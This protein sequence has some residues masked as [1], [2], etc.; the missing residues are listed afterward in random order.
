MSLPLTPV[1]IS[2]GFTLLAQ[3]GKPVPIFGLDLFIGISLPVRLPHPGACGISPELA[4]KRPRTRASSTSRTPM[5]LAITGP[6]TSS[7]TH[8][9]ATSPSAW[10]TPAAGSWWS[11]AARANARFTNLS[12]RSCPPGS[13]GRR[14]SACRITDPSC[15]QRAFSQ[16]RTPGSASVFIVCPAPQMQDKTT[17]QICSLCTI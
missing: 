8:A 12:R 2:T 5:A 6:M 13:P 15:R 16:G 17:F 7:L 10:T 14:E 4:P 11:G 1:F 9:S 3:A